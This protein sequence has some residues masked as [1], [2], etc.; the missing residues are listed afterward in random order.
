M[1]R[2]HR[3]PH[4]HAAITAG[5]GLALALGTSFASPSVVFA[6]NASVT[7]TQQH[8]EGATYDAFM[9]FSAD[10]DEH[11]AATHITWASDVMKKLV[12]DYL[13]AHGYGAWLSTRH[14][15]AGQH[16]RAQNACEYV[17]QM[18]AGSAEDKAAAT[19]PR[20]TDGRSF[21]SDLARHLA[22]NNASPRQIATSGTPFTEKEGYWLFVTTDTTTSDDSEAGSA[23]IWLPLGGSVTSILEKTSIPTVEKQVREDSSGAWSSV[24][25]AHT[26]QEIAYRLV[27]SLPQNFGAFQHYHYRF[28]D[29]LSQGL[30][31]PVPEGKE[32][33]ELISIKIGNKEVP[34]DGTKVSAAYEG[35]VLIVDFADLKSESWAEYGIDSNATITVEYSAHL[36]SQRT[37]G[38]PG[39]ANGVQLTYT[40][41]PVSDGDGH[42]ANIPDMTKAYAYALTL[43]KI[44]EQTGEP[45]ENARFSMQVS[46]ES[47]D[48]ASRGKYVQQDGS[49]SAQAYEFV[50]GSDGTFTVEGIDEGTYIVHET[51]A[52]EGYEEID[53]DVTVVVSSTLDPNTKLPTT[54][55][56]TVSGGDKKDVNA[57]GATEIT[58]TDA[59]AGSIALTVTNDR[60]IRMP[61]TGL[62]GIGSTPM[63][64]A[65]LAI[66]A[67]LSIALR[68][69]LP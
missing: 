44:D 22:N 41:D 59:T 65:A 5:L 26:G 30:E 51:Q 4:H 57:V 43:S 62:S 52:P 38:A 45:L 36:T 15:G 60:M 29:T 11:D 58:S 34:V 9:L 32:I 40:D 37:I 47:S 19:T 28:T 10:I 50:T 69:R 20:T 17:S 39:N 6:E 7:I 16:D 27:G 35:N 56:A 13:D 68:R 2:T 3:K 67:G 1:I 64:G 23:P 48:E 53:E 14:P 55:T 24:A 8:N 21:A 12:L 49:L 63:A 66:C 54:L 18:I 25:D 42:T 46:Q 31:I 33:A 61:L